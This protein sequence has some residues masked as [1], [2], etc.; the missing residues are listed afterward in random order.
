M[1]ERFKFS[2]ILASTK[3]KRSERR[4]FVSAQLQTIDAENIAKKTNE[5]QKTKQKKQN[6]S[7]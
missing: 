4:I 1:K 6:T 3:K 2:A 5:M 7:L